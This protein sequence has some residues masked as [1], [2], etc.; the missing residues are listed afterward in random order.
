MVNDNTPPPQRIS[1]RTAL[2]RFG[3][4]GLAIAVTGGLGSL[5]AACSGGTAAPSSS[6]SGTAGGAGT[7]GAG[8]ASGAA[9][10]SGTASGTGS[11]TATSP[12]P[13]PT[14]AP[15]ANLSV[16]FSSD[17]PSLDIATAFVGNVST[18]CL[19]V[20]EQLV[21][22]D[23]ELKLVGALA[24]KW[25]QPKNTQWLFTLR[26]GVTFWN[27]KPLTV[28]DVVYS[29]K[30]NLDPNFGSQEAAY[31]SNVDTIDASGDDGV[32]I[33]L[34]KPDETFP[35]ILTLFGIVNKAIAE[36]LGN[37]Y[38][39]PG[40]TIMG[41]GPYQVTS[42]VAKK[43]IE[44]K[45]YENYWGPKPVPDTISAK[46]IPDETSRQL[47]MRS[48]DAIMCYDV[49]SSLVKQWTQ[50]PNVE[51]P[52][53]L[54]LETTNLSFDLT[55]KPWDDIHIRRAFAHCWDP[56]FVQAVLAKGSSAAT[57]FVPKGMW[58]SLLD[59][60]ATNALYAKLPT[61]GFDLNA[62]KAE[63]AKSSQ[64]KG[65]TAE[66]K[67]SSASPSHLKAGLSLAENLAKIGVTLTV[68]QQDDSAW[69][70]YLNAHKDLGLQIKGTGPDYPDPT[71]YFAMFTTA[72]ASANG[73]NLANYKDPEFDK[74]F[75][76]QLGELDKAKR[77]GD[78]EKLLTMFADAMPVL[79]LWWSGF[80]IAYRKDKMTYSHLTSMCYLQS[81]T[82]NVTGP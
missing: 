50:I 42:F 67:V 59:D 27:G 38:A 75:Q 16:S 54:G 6:G 17:L 62:A 46:I 31:F 78:L 21:T 10:A 55:Q 12:G 68:T 71:D 73:T 9:S 37:K 44:L 22:Y 56:Q 25:S 57:S 23:N 14:N 36:P 79:P 35:Y 77:I 4:G 60:A 3:L 39:Q 5:L 20:H 58:A 63:L 34:K 45:R 53:G 19:L 1:R 49:S 65:F 15:L 8:S 29:L 30:R 64:P 28:D 72:Q 32:L 11:G 51:V 69:Q 13:A 33:T 61:Y 18:M 81:W 66:L 47:A 82:A 24:S 7:S 70:T 80:A 74:I 26:K 41:T 76:E 52:A 48:G 2:E 40:G 43:G